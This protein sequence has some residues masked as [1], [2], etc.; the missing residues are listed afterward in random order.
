VC[1]LLAQEQGSVFTGKIAIIVAFKEYSGK[2]PWNYTRLFYI[3]L[4]YSMTVQNL[5]MDVEL[6]KEL[7]V[8]WSSLCLGT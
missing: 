7:C 4:V 8:K 6:N 2:V 3:L 1:C 5:L